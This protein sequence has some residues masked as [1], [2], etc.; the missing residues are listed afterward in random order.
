MI[1]RPMVEAIQLI[2]LTGAYFVRSAMIVA[3]E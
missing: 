1:W 3:L 2:I